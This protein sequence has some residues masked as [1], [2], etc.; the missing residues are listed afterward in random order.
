MREGGVSTGIIV[1]GRTLRGRKGWGQAREWARP[2]DNLVSSDRGRGGGSLMGNNSMVGVH[3]QKGLVGTLP[4]SGQMFCYFFTQI[5]CVQN[6][7]RMSR[8]ACDLGPVFPRDGECC[9][10]VSAPYSSQCPTGASGK[11]TAGD[12]GWVGRG[13]VEERSGA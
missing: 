9:R 5:V 6:A 8:H 7:V 10:E 12:G 1:W 3:A 2:T 11:A 4:S 13:R